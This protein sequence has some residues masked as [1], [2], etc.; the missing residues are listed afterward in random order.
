MISFCRALCLA[1]KKP[2]SSASAELTS[3][4]HE[5]DS[6]RATA[7]GQA[8]QIDAQSWPSR[9]PRRPY[10][11][12]FPH[13]FCLSLSRP[14]QAKQC[15]LPALSAPTSLQAV[16]QLKRWCNTL[17]WLVVRLGHGPHKLLLWEQAFQNELPSLDMEPI[18]RLLRPSHLWLGK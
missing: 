14:G 7:R 17:A 9:E 1:C 16:R 13:D 6:A 4:M 18:G 10:A 5:P 12:L 15:R 8:V 3:R 2:S 11:S